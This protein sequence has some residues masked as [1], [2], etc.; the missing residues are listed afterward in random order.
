[1][2][3]SPIALLL[4]MGATPSDAQTASE[5]YCGQFARSQLEQSF[6]RMQVGVWPMNFDT[7]ISCQWNLGRADAVASSYDLMVTLLTSPDHSPEL[8]V[9][10][11]KSNIGENGVMLPG[12]G[13]GAGYT[14]WDGKQGPKSTVRMFAAKGS[15]KFQLNVESKSGS[16]D[17][18]TLQQA[19]DFFSS[20]VN[21]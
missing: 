6:D 17:N 1:M 20:V 9:K 18:R 19:K 2:R 7:M 4:V 15:Q 12:I 14:F 11:T 13:D 16:L 10:T 21:K 5:K 3:Y 8:A